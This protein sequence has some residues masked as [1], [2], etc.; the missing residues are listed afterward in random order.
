M[1]LIASLV[2]VSLLTACATTAP[3][4]GPSSLNNSGVGYD[5]VRIEDDRWRVTYTAE[6]DRAELE[7]ERFALR[8]AADL[9]QRNGYDW[10]QVVDRRIRTDGVDRSPVRVGGSISQG[11]G[12]GGYRGTGVGIGVS[13]SPQ[14][15]PTAT[16]TLE[17]IAGQGMPA[18]EGAYDAASIMLRSPAT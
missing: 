18:P 16:T 5:D 10:F 17:I 1:R 7:S 11:I 14:A 8:R 3:G 12:S 2:L 9:A 6:G 13:I 4:Y 15:K